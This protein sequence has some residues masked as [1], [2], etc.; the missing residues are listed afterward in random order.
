MRSI[1]IAVLAASVAAAAQLGLGYGLGII[2]WVSP[3]G[4]GTVVTEPGAWAAGLA[5]VTWVATTS[6]V[7]GAV[8]ADRYA[9][10][11]ESGP[12]V[13][14]AWRLV[15]TLAATI[16][17][18]VTVPLVA[19]PASAAQLGDNFAPHLLASVHTVTGAVLGLVIALAALASRAIA[20]NVFAT[21]GWLWALAIVAVVD[22]F[23]ASRGLGTA[24][25][26]VWRF[27]DGGP[28][29]RDFYIPGALLMLGAALLIGGLAAF[30]AAN[31]GD[32]R[33]GVA[34]SGAVGPL[35]VAVAYVLTSPTSDNAPVEQI[36]AYLTA[37][38][39]VLAGLAGSILVAAVGVIPGRRRTST[40]TSTRSAAETGTTTTTAM[41]P[42]V[43]QEYPG[44]L[45]P[46]TVSA[47][48]S[49]PASSRATPDEQATALGAQRVRST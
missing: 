11:V 18:L 4:A 38:Y 25:L 17:G 21:A 46:A 22:G 16:G 15:I 36:S 3:S 31:R 13:R 44:G 7:I 39:T 34:S 48:A 6:V 20:A 42:A 45:A 8:S 14:T 2:S 40:R 30:P 41:E 1:V 26:G 19:V 49:V 29:W 47:K 5:W 28:M 35:I 10:R 12:W 9:G 32:G 33:I 43:D 23:L 24:Q 27:T 37:P